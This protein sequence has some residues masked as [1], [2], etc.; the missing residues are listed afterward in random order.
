MNTL[1]QELEQIIHQGV[2]ARTLGHSV[3]SCTRCGLGTAP[4]PGVPFRVQVK[5]TPRDYVGPQT[6]PVAFALQ[7]VPERAR[8]QEPLQAPP[9]PTRRE[10]QLQARS[11]GYTG[12]FCDIC[13]ST[14]MVRNGTCAK[15]DD[16]GATSG[17]S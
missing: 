16:C 14:R 15:C 3:V 12:D 8:A 5:Y 10:Q 11:M 13:Q 2:C 4:C 17:C 1:Q 9:P 7:A 6:P